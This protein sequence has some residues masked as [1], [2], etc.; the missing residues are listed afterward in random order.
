MFRPAGAGA[1]V[2]WTAC[3]LRETSVAPVPRIRRSHLRERE[4]STVAIARAQSH[5]DGVPTT[6]TRV[7]SLGTPIVYAGAF[8]SVDADRR[9]RRRRANCT[10]RTTAAETNPPYHAPRAD[11]YAVRVFGGQKRGDEHVDDDA[12]VSTAYVTDTGGRAISHDRCA[13][14]VPLAAIVTQLCT[15]SCYCPGP[16]YLIVCRTSLME[17]NTTYDAMAYLHCPRPAPAASVPPPAASSPSNCIDNVTPSAGLNVSL[18]LSLTHSLFLSHALDRSGS[19]SLRYASPRADSEPQRYCTPPL[20]RFP[21]DY[22][23]A[24]AT[25]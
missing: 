5:D 19:H 7:R 24:A 14:V 3:L 4:V 18:S 8:R 16:C 10:T 21:D 17:E 23:A 12:N 15:E 6:T 25:S 2:K 13:A 11:G 20:T 22:H 1:S 9:R